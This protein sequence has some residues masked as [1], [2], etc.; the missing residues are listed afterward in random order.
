M[1]Y[2]REIK[3]VEGKIIW[4]IIFNLISCLGQSSQNLATN[5]SFLPNLPIYY[6]EGENPILTLF[7][8]FQLQSTA[9]GSMVNLVG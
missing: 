3:N 1:L 2:K 5:L 9:Y 8:G 6:K 4:L 7:L